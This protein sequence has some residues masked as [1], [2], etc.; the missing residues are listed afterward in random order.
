MNCWFSVENLRPNGIYEFRIRA[1]NAEGLGA[2]SR[3][4]PATVIRPAAPQRGTGS[5]TIDDR[6][7]P[8]G[9][10]QVWTQNLF[11]LEFRKFYAVH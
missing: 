1:R 7:Q 10:P 11:Q 6:I 3:P 9:Q 5:R 8:P 2:P 4:S